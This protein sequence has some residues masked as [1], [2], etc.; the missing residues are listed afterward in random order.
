LT[1]LSKYGNIKSGR[2]IL[3]DFLLYSRGCLIMGQGFNGDKGVTTA[4][5]EILTVPASHNVPN[6]Y[7]ELSFLNLQACTVKING[8]NPI[9]LD[10]EQGVETDAND[11][12]IYSLVVVESG[13]DFKWFGKY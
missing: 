5:Q 4:S 3:P 13:I 9:P 10:P 6:Y 2:K 8:G 7:Y 12:K 1:D 11:A